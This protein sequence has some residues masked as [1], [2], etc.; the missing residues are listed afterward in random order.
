M[1]KCPLFSLVKPFLVEMSFQDN[2][3]NTPT[4]RVPD[5]FL[6]SR[7]RWPLELPTSHHSR[8]KT[9]R[10]NE[11]YSAQPLGLILN[12]TTQAKFLFREGQPHVVVFTEL[13]VFYIYSIP[14]GGRN[15]K[16]THACPDAHCCPL[17]LSG[18]SVPSSSPPPRLTFPHR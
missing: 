15:N 18:S 4:S 13:C 7:D 3:R 10:Q 12:Q 5:G 16:K 6:C 17:H 9:S 1:S 11:C 14:A 2:W 8:K